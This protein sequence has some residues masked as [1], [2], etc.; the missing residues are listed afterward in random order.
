MQTGL[1]EKYYLM[2]KAIR[3]SAFCLLKFLQDYIRSVFVR[4]AHDSG[5]CLQISAFIIVAILSCGVH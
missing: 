2:H 3:S 5:N 4:S 1:T